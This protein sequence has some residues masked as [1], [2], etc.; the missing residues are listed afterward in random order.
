MASGALK[1]APIR[2]YH[3]TILTRLPVLPFPRPY[4]FAAVPVLTFFPFSCAPAGSAIL[5][6]YNS[7]APFGLA[8]YRPYHFPGPACS[9]VFAFP[10]ARPLYLFAIFTNRTV[11]SHLSVLPILPPVSIFG[12]VGFNICSIVFCAPAGY[13]F[14]NFPI[15]PILP[16]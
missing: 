6:F 10:F 14:N 7:S 4:Q 11:F 13:R 12:H 3:F 8:I 2:N 1:D 5:Q 16:F 15:L 9:N